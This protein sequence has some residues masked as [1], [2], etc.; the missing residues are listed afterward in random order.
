MN[1]F[2][3][4][5]NSIETKLYNINILFVLF[6]FFSIFFLIGLIAYFS[7][8]INK[9]NIRSESFINKKIIILLG[10]SLLNNSKYVASGESIYDILSEKKNVAVINY[11]TDDS[12]ISNVYSQLNKISID[13]NNS[14]TFIFLSV[15]G[16]DILKLINSQAFSDSEF[17]KLIEKYNILVKSIEARLPFTKVVLLTLFYPPDTNIFKKY[18]K[19]I[20]IWNNNIFNNYN[21][22]IDI[23]S[24][25]NSNNDIVENIEPSFIGSKKIASNIYTYTQ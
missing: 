21:Y 1:N 15:G 20:E 4:I 5:K 11:A 19:Y 2:H 24:F 10:D 8:K 7:N 12:F 23:S 13:F 18:Y 14:N 6:I 25:I 22:Y 17:Y 16:N 9:Y 3:L